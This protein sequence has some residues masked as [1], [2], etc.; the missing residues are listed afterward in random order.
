MSL[1]L[2]QASPMGGGK[3]NNCK[4]AHGKNPQENTGAG[5]RDVTQEPLL[6]EVTVSRRLGK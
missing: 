6:A 1:L 2:V 3:K 5:R 4:L